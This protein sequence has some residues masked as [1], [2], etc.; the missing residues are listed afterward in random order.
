MT[1]E[2]GFGGKEGGKNK[3]NIVRALCCERKGGGIKLRGCEGAGDKQTV[4]EPKQ[5]KQQMED[6]GGKMNLKTESAGIF[7]T[8]EFGEGKVNGRRLNE[9]IKG[10]LH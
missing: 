10:Y 2:T 4:L 9:M 5:Q 7:T 3:K 6:S 1:G 8:P